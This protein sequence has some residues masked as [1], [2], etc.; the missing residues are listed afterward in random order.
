[1]VLLKKFELE[2]TTK[3]LPINLTNVLD[4]EV[5]HHGETKSVVHVTNT[6]GDNILINWDLSREDKFVT[7][8]VTILISL[9][10]L[11][12]WEGGR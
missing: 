4:L 9:L 6:S 11:W 12:G 5:V 1:M 3:L 2:T 7:R 10:A 8:H